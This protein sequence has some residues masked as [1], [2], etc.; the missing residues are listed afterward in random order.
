MRTHSSQSAKTSSPRP[1][2]LLISVCVLALGVVAVTGCGHARSEL[3]YAEATRALLSENSSSIATCYDAH[4]QTN[5]ALAGDV[6]VDFVV[7]EKTGAISNAVVDPAASTA[8]VELA[9]CVV[10]TISGQH[11]AEPDR[12]RGVGRFQWSFQAVPASGAVQQADAAPAESSAR[13]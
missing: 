11:L 4:L 6:V 10:N 12:R 13:Q 1:A 2:S 9:D 7:D 5:A 3:E 8:P